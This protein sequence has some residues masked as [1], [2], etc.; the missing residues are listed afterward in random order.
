VKGGGY[1]PAS[2]VL[3]IPRPNPFNPSM[4]NDS[5]YKAGISPISDNEISDDFSLSFV[6]KSYSLR[7]FSVAA[8][9]HSYVSFIPRTIFIPLV[10]TITA[11]GQPK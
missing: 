11:R 4:G 10:F 7:G 8:H 6:L 1:Q 3:H 5:Q 9:K 2:T